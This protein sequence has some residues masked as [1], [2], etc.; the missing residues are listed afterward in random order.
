LAYEEKHSGYIASLNTPENR[1]IY[2]QRLLTTHPFA[3]T[4]GDLANIAVDE[5]ECEGSIICTSHIFGETFEM[6]L[7]G[8]A[9]SETITFPSVIHSVADIEIKKVGARYH[10]TKSSASNPNQ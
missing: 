3:T 4:P 7:S 6:L 9:I 10:A 8:V 1:K 5:V 2:L